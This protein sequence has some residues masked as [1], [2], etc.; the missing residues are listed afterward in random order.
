LEVGRRVVCRRVM[1]GGE[2]AGVIRC[3]VGHVIF[4]EG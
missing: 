2:I 4:V 1:G 3:C